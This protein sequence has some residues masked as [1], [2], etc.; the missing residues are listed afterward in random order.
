M[1]GIL[2]PDVGNYQ[3]GKGFLTFKPNGATDFYHVGNVPKFSWTPKI[4]PLPHKSSMA[5]TKVQD[6][7]I[8]QE[9][10]GEVSMDME[11][12]TANNMAM[13]NQGD[14]DA[15]NPD[16]VIVDIMSKKDLVIGRLRFYATNDVGPRWN[17]DFLQVQFNP[18]S[19]FN[20]ISDAY[21]A[22]TVQGLVL[23]Q[24]GQWGTWTKVPP[25]SQIVPQNVTAP[26]ITGPL[27]EGFEPAFAKVGETM[28]A[29][30]GGWIG[31]TSVAYQ[32]KKGGS[33]ISGATDVVYIP[34]VGDIGGILTVDVTVTNVNGST[35]VTSGPTLA[36]HA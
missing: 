25:A 34:V 33:P 27:K 29:Q 19:P 17:G 2:A 35:T 7:S 21:N 14:I 18:T 11:E 15:T 16:A 23:I 5:G 26:F 1:S 6:F 36:V 32:W 28:T 22:M 8:I 12:L 13:F 3:V 10:A 24:N 20:P 31:I 30:A 9:R 4:T